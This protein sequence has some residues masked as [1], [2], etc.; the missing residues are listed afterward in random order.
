MEKINN[1]RPGT[2]SSDSILL[3][4]SSATTDDNTMVYRPSLNR[5]HINLNNVSCDK[6]YDILVSG[7]MSCYERE[8]NFELEIETAQLEHRKI[9]MKYLYQLAKFLKSLKQRDVQYL[10]RTH[11]YIYDQFTYNLLYTLFTYLSSPIAPVN[12]VYLIARP[13]E[14]IYRPAVLDTSLIK[15]FKTFYPMTS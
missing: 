3:G 15:Q 7:I 1:V 13:K 5:Y 6:S 10:K 14:L 11:I 9:K 8:H 4:V 2:L 12:V